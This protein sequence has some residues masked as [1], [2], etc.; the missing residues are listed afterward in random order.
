M[1]TRG[2]V[3]KGKTLR[4]M[5][6]VRRSMT[7]HGLTE[8]ATRGRDTWRSLLVVLGEGKLLLNVKVLR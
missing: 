4:E 6:G 1:E 7:N 2:N 5:V 3:K 8:E